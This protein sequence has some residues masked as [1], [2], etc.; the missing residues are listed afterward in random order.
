[1]RKAIEL[2][3]AKGEVHREQMLIQSRKMGLP[4]MAKD[5]IFLIE[6]H[7]RTLSHLFEHGQLDPKEHERFKKEVEDFDK[8]VKRMIE[9]GDGR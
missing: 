5:D 7:F 3:M 2:G 8:M 9:S 1:M 4:V 6:D